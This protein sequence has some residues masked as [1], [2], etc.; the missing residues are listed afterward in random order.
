M[1][2]TI[3]FVSPESVLYSGEGT[4]VTA[5]TRGGGDIAFLT[6]HE[7][8]IGSLQTSEIKVTEAEGTVKRF[9]VRG[10]FVSVAGNKVTVL[11]DLAV[12]AEDI[13]VKSANDDLADAVSRLS[14]DDLDAFAMADKKWAE[15][16]IELAA[17]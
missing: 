11:S 17:S 15:L 8:F 10:G 5:R 1:S 14:T 16:R 2:F 12:P 6:G 7:P 13:D 9:A 3:E 4:M